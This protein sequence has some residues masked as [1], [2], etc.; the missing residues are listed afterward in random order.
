MLS[1]DWDHFHTLKAEARRSIVRS[2]RN[3]INGKLNEYGDDPSLFW[4][5]MDTNLNIGKSRSTASMCDHIKNKYGNIVVGD[6]VLETFN[7]F[8]VSIG[9][10]LSMKFPD[11]DVYMYVPID[12]KKQCTFRFVGMKEVKSVIKA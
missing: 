7:N 9:K 11:T 12:V 8:Y 4:R 6:D 10:E 2:K 3:Y 1:G 5:E